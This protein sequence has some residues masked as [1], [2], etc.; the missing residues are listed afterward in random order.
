MEHSSNSHPIPDYLK[1]QNKFVPHMSV[2]VERVDNVHGSTAG[3]GSGDFH[4]YR[5]LRRKERYRLVRM[6]VEHRRAKEKEEHE[7]RR[8]DRDLE[9][10]L[11]TEKKSAKRRLKKEKA[12]LLKK[13]GKQAGEEVRNMLRAKL[14]ASESYQSD[15]DEDRKEAS[16]SS[17]EEEESS[18]G[19]QIQ[20]EQKEAQQSE[21]IKPVVGQKR[22]QQ[23]QAPKLEGKVEEPVQQRKPVTYQVK[24]I[25]EDA[26]DDNDDEEGSDGSAYRFGNKKRVHQ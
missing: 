23:Q 17:D 9:C 18:I 12:K 4:Q 10:R 8:K 16:S 1:S 2:Q 6:E 26:I 13:V 21:T 11:K 24:I 3:A 5:Q 19:P 14:N 20:V 25:D 15:S 22:F 7:E